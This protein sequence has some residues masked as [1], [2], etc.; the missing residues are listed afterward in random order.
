MIEDLKKDEL[1]EF[2]KAN[3]EI[4]RQLEIQLRK[5]GADFGSVVGRLVSK[6][7]PPCTHDSSRARARACRFCSRLR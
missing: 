6:L 1:A 7:P 2:I 3:E 4:L 5:Q